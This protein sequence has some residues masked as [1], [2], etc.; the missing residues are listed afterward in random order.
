[1]ID[2]HFAVMHK[3]R[4]E[5]DKASVTELT[6]QVR[7]KVAIVGD[8]VIMT[9]GTLLAGAEALRE[10]GATAVWVFTSHGLFSDGALERFG[11]ADLAG[12]VVT[13]TVPIDPVSRPENLTVL[14]IS[15]LLA[16]TIMNVFADESVSAIFGGEY[17]LF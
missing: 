15:G 11:E 9:G 17:Q 8:D 13:D 16:E 3:T 7:D 10:H 4:P 1:M 2:G 12:I 14:P 5:H 6:G